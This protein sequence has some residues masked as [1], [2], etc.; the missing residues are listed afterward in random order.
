MSMARLLAEAW[1]QGWSS[2]RCGGGPGCPGPGDRIARYADRPWSELRSRQDVALV[3]LGWRGKRDRGADGRRHPPA[4]PVDG[5]RP[6]LRQR[7][8]LPGHPG[9]NAVPRTAGGELVLALAGMLKCLHKSVARLEE[10]IE[11]A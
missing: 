11:L 10:A 7:R 5:D 6:P 1:V 2:P 8:G 4:H 9:L 3:Y